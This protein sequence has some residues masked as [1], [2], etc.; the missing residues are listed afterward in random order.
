LRDIL[1]TDYLQAQLLA[2]AVKE[3]T[4]D[5]KKPGSPE[6]KALVTTAAE[7]YGEVYDKYRTRLAGLYARM[8]QGRCSQKLGNHKDALSYFGELLEQPDNPEEFRTLKTKTLL[9]AK[10]SWRAAS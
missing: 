1:R 10:D 3:E 8:Y 5:T 6:Y 4:A 2:A 9:L 7:Q